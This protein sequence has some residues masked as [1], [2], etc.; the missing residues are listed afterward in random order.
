MNYFSAIDQG[1][2]STRFIVFDEDGH[3][4]DQHQEEFTQY[5]PDQYSVEHNPEE[6]WNSV[7]NCINSVLTRVDVKKIISVGITNQRETTIAWSKST[8]KPLYNA[9]V[10]QDTRT[11][12]IC[13]EI[14]NNNELEQEFKKTGLPIATYFSLSKIIWLMK[15]VPDVKKSLENNDVIFGTVDSWLIYKLNESL[16]TDVTNASRT[17]LFDLESLNW[18]ERILNE[19]NIPIDSLPEIKPSLSNFGN[20]KNI[21]NNVPI[22]AVLGDQQASLFGQQCFN[23]GSVKN[24]YGTGCF[25]LTNTGTEIIYSNNGLLTTVAY[26]YGDNEANYAIE[27]SV[28]IAGAGVQW[29]RDNLNLINTS[30]EIERFALQ[31][32]DNG[33]VYFVPAFSGLFSPHWDPTA[34]GILVGLSRFSNKNHIARAVL[35][36][37]AYQSYELIDSMEKDIGIEF[38]EIKVDGGM[39]VNNLLMQF[40]SDIF[41]KNLI[42]K[43]IKEITAYGAGLAS[44]IFLKGI[45]INELKIEQKIS[46]TWSPNISI[47][48][49]NNYIDMWSKAIEKS[50][51]WI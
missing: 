35:E 49:R 29:L 50:K 46:N 32:K 26:K 28:A 51:N 5:L 48:K 17:L 31:E 44:Y 39:I 9:L 42:A 34:R 2:T 1:T 33:G 19:Y 45:E 23:R 22:T 18:N 36:S 15:N 7:V 24:T 25:A 30:D 40:Q 11:Q 13:N 4:I 37:V 16:Q 21:L 10:W 27:G 14:I 47:D 12:D 20:C 38:N 8:G 41:N 3:V 43:N 6:I